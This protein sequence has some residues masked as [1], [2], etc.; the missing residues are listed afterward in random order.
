MRLAYIVGAPGVPVHG[1]SGCSAHVRSVVRGMAA[2]GETRL[3]AAQDVD[4]RGRFG[5]PTEAWVGG[6]PGWPSWLP[7]FR[8]M[9]EVWAARRIA[10]KVVE[11]GLYDWKPDLIVERHALFSDAGWRASTRLRV[12]WVLEVNAPLVL[13]RQRFETVLRPEW[14]KQWEFDVLRAAPAIA[15]VSRWLTQWLREEVGCRNVHW[16]PNGVDADIGDR[17]RGRQLLGLEPDEPAIGFVG[18]F[19]P[20]HGYERLPALAKALDARLVH[21]GGECESIHTD[22]RVIHAGHRSGAALADVVAALDLGLAPYPSTAPPWFC[23]LKVFSY[24]A[25]GVPVVTSDIGDAAVLVRGGGTA[26]PADDDDALKRAAR[27][28][29]GRRCTPRIRSWTTVARELLTLGTTAPSVR[30][31]WR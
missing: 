11:D 31:Q 25:Q 29:L 6:V 28:W 5:V 23:P 19:K 24:R 17:A 4:R 13:E 26:V 21:I 18:S 12:P 15:A 14:A 22:G 20:W 2:F 1:P 9:R 10:R 7:Q 30:G 27:A 8:E 3:Y 16:V